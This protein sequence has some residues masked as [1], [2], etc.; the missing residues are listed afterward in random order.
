M[1]FE[2]PFLAVLSMLMAIVGGHI[3][4]TRNRSIVI[5]KRLSSLESN[6]ITEDKVKKM[7]EDAQKPLTMILEQVK[8]SID[9]NKLVSNRLSGQLGE[10]NTEI[11]VF[12]SEIQHL[13]NRND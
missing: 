2:K 3:V 11:A 5:E 1:D 7:I 8:E 13:Q 9:E 4:F 6:Q 10:L 12:K